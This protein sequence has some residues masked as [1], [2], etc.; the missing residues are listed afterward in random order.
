M[1]NQLTD[2]SNDNFIEEIQLDF[3]EDKLQ[4]LYKVLYNENTTSRNYVDLMKCVILFAPNFA[5]NE[6]FIFQ[7]IDDKENKK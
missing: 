1:N 2:E 6:R 3:I 7:W 4:T 5:P